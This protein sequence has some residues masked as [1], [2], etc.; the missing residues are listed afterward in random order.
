M[1]RRSKN[2][3]KTQRLAPST[4]SKVA[5]RQTR[6]KMM[7]DMNENR[8]HTG[9]LA[10]KEMLGQ[11]KLNIYILYIICMIRERERELDIP[12]IPITLAR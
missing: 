12:I 3:K 2:C 11:A 10:Q 5:S 4:Y 6:H 9:I 1:I 8:I 7:V